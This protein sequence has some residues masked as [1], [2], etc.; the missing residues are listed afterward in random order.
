VRKVQ[1]PL[2]TWCLLFLF[3]ADRVTADKVTTRYGLVG[4]SGTGGRRW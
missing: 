4:E 1:S 2:T 3:L